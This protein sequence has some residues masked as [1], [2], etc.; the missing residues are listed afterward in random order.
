MYIYFIKVYF[1]EMWFL[2]LHFSKVYAGQFY[3]IELILFPCNSKYGAGLLFSLVSFFDSPV[4]LFLIKCCFETSVIGYSALYLNFQNVLFVC[5]LWPIKK[6]TLEQVF[7]IVFSLQLSLFYTEK[8]QSGFFM[9]KFTTLM[10]YIYKNGN[11]NNTE[12]QLLKN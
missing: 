9:L 4:F 10:N 11:R 2:L 3:Y 7:Y 1:I 6:C 5:L 12:I 8:V